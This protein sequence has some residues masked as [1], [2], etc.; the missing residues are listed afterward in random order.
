M[1]LSSASH[2]L[3]PAF[4]KWHLSRVSLSAGQTCTRYHIRQRHFLAGRRRLGPILPS[5]PWSRGHPNECINDGHRR[6]SPIYPNHYPDY[7]QPRLHWTF[8][9]N[10]TRRSYLPCDAYNQWLRN[11]Y[12]AWFG[13]QQAHSLPDADTAHKL[14]HPLSLQRL[15]YK[16]ADAVDI[17]CSPLC[18][19]LGG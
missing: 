15:H 11:P 3:P 18:F 10:P 1:G 9:S 13:W 2:L 17:P 14:S 12:S 5:Y 19:V 6:L 4:S 7:H 8:S 16:P